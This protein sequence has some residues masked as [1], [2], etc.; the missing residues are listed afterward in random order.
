MTF[1]LPL[2]AIFSSFFVQFLPPRNS[3]TSKKL[4]LNK[5]SNFLI[6]IS[7][8]TH[9]LG[10]FHSTTLDDSYIGALYF[11][12]SSKAKLLNIL[13]FWLE[14]VTRETETSILDNHKRNTKWKT[15]SQNIFRSSPLPSRD[16]TSF[17][18]VCV[19]RSFSL[20]TMR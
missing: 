5:F 1:T 17:F 11:Y 4:Q 10:L 13:V 15:I 3:C 16:Y 6:T 19:A 20:S 14:P 18:S 8:P 9:P 7:A 12:G 2:W